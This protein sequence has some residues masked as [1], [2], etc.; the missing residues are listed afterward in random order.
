MRALTTI[1]RRPGVLITN[2]TACWKSRLLDGHLANLRNYGYLNATRSADFLW[3]KE[4]LIAF[5]EKPVELVQTVVET[6]VV[7]IDANHPQ[8]AEDLAWKSMR[9]NGE[10]TDELGRS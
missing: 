3:D 1:R 4:N 10:R 7:W 2:Q 9:Q 6:A 5:I 8:E